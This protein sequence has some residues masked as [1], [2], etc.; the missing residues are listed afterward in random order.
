MSVKDY[1]KEKLMLIIISVLSVFHL[2]VDIALTVT[3]TRFFNRY[4]LDSIQRVSEAED[5]YFKMCAL[6]GASSLLFIVIMLLATLS[7]YINAGNTLRSNSR[8]F[9]DAS[10]EAL[11]EEYKKD[12]KKNI[13]YVVIFSVVSAIAY[14]TYIF[15]RH[16]LPVTTLFN[17]IAE[18]TFM[19][20]FIKAML[21]IYD[22][23][24]KRIYTHA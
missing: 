11:M 13:I 24:Y 9:V 16:L 10:R 5:I 14:C 6:A 17:S 18:I 3:A 20:A 1:F 12:A 22:N 4:N 2:S 19:F 7:I 15:S 8:L 23:V 21:Y